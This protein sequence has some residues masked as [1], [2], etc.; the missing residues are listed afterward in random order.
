MLTSSSISNSRLVSVIS[1]KSVREATSSYTTSN[2]KLA[3]SIAIIDITVYLG[4]CLISIC[5]D[6]LLLKFVLAPIIG[7]SIGLL[8]VVGHDCCHKS[9]FSNRR[10]NSIVGVI[11]MLPSLH[12]Y[13]LWD[14]G[15]NH[16]HHKYTNLKTH[17]YVYRPLSIGEYSSL[18]YMQKLRYRIYRSV[19]GHLI[20]YLIEI[21]MHKMVLPH[22]GIPGIKSARGYV[23]Y[24]LPLLLYISIFCGVVFVLSILTSQSLL[25]NFFSVIVL[26][27]L[28]W[29][30][31]MGFIIYQHHTGPDARWYNDPDEWQYWECQVMDSIHIKFPR[32][33]NT[34]IH[35]IMEHTAHH[36][37]MGIPLYNLNEAQSQLEKSLGSSI[38]VIEWS[39]AYYFETVKSCKLY[40]Y[41]S[42]SWLPF[43][44]KT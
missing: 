9:F 39:L 6:I 31:I 44:E 38:T 21:W 29:N 14:L 10:A 12:N 42:H 13:A 41:D 16:T 35:N 15:H 28:V 30:W 7:L 40:D 17:D 8:F 24:F 4:L 3:W 2:E 32:V 25:L 33:V 43:P 22:R 1:A 20:Y 37:N 5:T 18:S 19:F 34:L 11:S 36:A 27:F 23:F 26:P